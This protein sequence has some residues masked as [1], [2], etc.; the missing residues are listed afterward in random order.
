MKN[1]KA[2]ILVVDD[3]EGIRNLVKKFLNEN[4]YLINTAETAEEAQR[5]IEIIQ[6]DF[7]TNSRAGINLSNSS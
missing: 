4:Y 2:H 6:F 7:A 1:Y 3:D 5:K